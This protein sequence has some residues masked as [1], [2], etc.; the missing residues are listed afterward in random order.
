M[1]L[2]PLYPG[3][4]I[5]AV[6]PSERGGGKTRPMVVA[7]EMADI[8][9]NHRFVAVVIS[10]TFEEPLTPHEVRIPLDPHIQHITKLGQDSVAV[11]N[12]IES[13]DVAEIKGDRGGRVPPHLL[14][15]VF[16]AAGIVSP[17]TR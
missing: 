3:R 4:I 16:T 10:H 8:Q 2:P 12:W 6:A 9:K 11:C 13:I 14:R 15:A 1:L 5:Y 17:R 7:S